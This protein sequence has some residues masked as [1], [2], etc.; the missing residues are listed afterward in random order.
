MP[1]HARADGVD[2]VYHLAGQTA[3]TTSVARPSRATSRRTRSARSTCSRRRAGA[4]TPPIVVYAST[5]KVYGGLEHLPSRRGGDALPL[6]RPSRT[7]STSRTPL[8]FH[9]PYGC[10][11]G[12][13]DQYVLDYAR[14]Y[15]AADGRLPPELHLRPAA[16]RVRGAG[17][18]GLVR[19][20]GGVRQADHHLR[21]RQAGAR[22]A[23]RR[24]PRRCLPARDRGDRDR[25]AGE[26]YNIGGGRRSHRLDL[27]GV[28]A[29]ARAPRSGARYPRRAS[30][31]ARPG[32]QPVFFCD[33]RK[34][35]T[36]LRL[37][38]ARSASRTGLRRSSRWVRR[39]PTEMLVARPLR[40][41]EGPAGA[42][43]LPAA[44][45]RPDDLRRAARARARRARPRGDRA[46]LPASDARF[47][48][49]RGGATASASSAC[50]SPS[51]S[52]RA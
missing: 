32:D 21:R 15:G 44:R 28:R 3:V 4:P 49:L 17:L 6:R 14:I 27:A 16:A 47:P 23:L 10:S 19:R 46:H 1:S 51:A 36:R 9:S 52:A 18:G 40:R 13:A 5:N 35:E 33:T 39:A 34:A 22:P 29:A 7:A 37:A 2:V 50:R 25:R 24:R 42:D 20:R 30:P 12:A 26:A 31:S 43:V 48:R 38:A 8:D 11:K 45:Q 41:D